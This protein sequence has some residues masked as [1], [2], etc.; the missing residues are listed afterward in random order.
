MGLLA[1]SIAPGIAICLFIYLKDKYNREPLGMLIISFLLGMIGIFPAIIV[2]L[3]SGI[4]L[5]SLTNKSIPEFAFFAFFVVALSEEMSKYVIV[6][7]FAYRRKSFDEP[8]DGIIYTVMVGMGFATL[9][10]IGYVYEHGF[11]TGIV[12]MFLSVPAHAT[13]A[14]LMGYHWGLA[15]F[16]IANRSKHLLLAIVLPVLFHGAFDFFL[17]TGNSLLHIAGA[18]L[19]FYVAIRLSG[20]AIRKHRQLSESFWKEKASVNDNN[21]PLY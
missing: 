6:R 2:Q 10:N 9:E 17:F 4:S 19:S 18:L 8:F 13:F 20:K 11:S 15:K 21:N 12:R 7:F 14:V 16:D 1:L 3:L 5:E